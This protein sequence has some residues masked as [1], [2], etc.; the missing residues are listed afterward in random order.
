MISDSERRRLDEIER[1]MRLDD[2]VFVRRF[3]ERQCTTRTMVCTTILA[4][5]AILVV[6]PFVIAVAVAIGGPQAALAVFVLPA[7]CVGVV[8]WQR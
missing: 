6:A 4:A 7:L 5:I 1:L 2:P 3:D 8:L